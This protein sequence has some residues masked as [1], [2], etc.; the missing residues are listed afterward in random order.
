[1]PHTGKDRLLLDSLY[2]ISQ[3]AQTTE[4]PTEALQHILN[5][6]VTLLPGN[7]A[8]IELINPDSLQLEIEVSHGFPS[9]SADTRLPIGHGITGWVA[10]HG[11]PLIVSDVRKDSRY[12]CLNPDVRSEMAVPL[13]GDEGH[14][15]G[16]VNIDSVHPDA[17]DREDL[18]VLTLITMEAGR[19]INKIWHVQQLREKTIH[20]ETLLDV[21][22]S[23]VTK[24]DLDEIL[25]TITRQTLQLLKGRT[26]AIFF[27][28]AKHQTLTL[29]GFSGMQQPH[30]D[31]KSVSLQDSAIGTAIRWNKMIEVNDLRRTEE[32][33]F[34]RF[35]RQEGLVSLLSCPMS[36]E[37]E[38][39]GVLNLYTD[40]PHRFNNEEKRLMETL[41]SLGAAAVQNARLYDRIFQSEE[42]LRQNERLTTLGL[43]SAEIAHEIR[44]PLT[45]IRLLF[46]T[47]SLEFEADDPRHRDKQVIGEKLDQLEEIVSRVLQFGKARHDLKRHFNLNELI[48]D[49]LVLVRPKLRQCRVEV[50]FNANAAS[51]PLVDVSKGQLQQAIL[52][53]IINA[54]QAMPG[55][56]VIKI[57]SGLR[58]MNDQRC[59]YVRFADSGQGIPGAIRDQIFEFF[60]SG[61]HEGTGL[62]LAVVKRILKSHNGDVAV[63]DST[64][65]GTVM[66]FWLPAI[67]RR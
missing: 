33:H 41:A 35:I 17:F 50:E 62:G 63:I 7:S 30:A 61:R 10:L 53:I 37:N 3:L 66:E 9:K 18:K 34:I 19:V 26:C 14:V 46:E 67:D 22:R 54:T 8:A 55:G 36:F 57:E 6:M 52:N 11:E 20:Q 40:K 16:V 32:H 58:P 64:D 5:E 12:V 31:E 1:M 49:T 47:L 44:N 45:V 15:I 24:R 13:R 29:R 48:D 43:L 65:E 27:H 2:R 51:P 59:A 25:Q 28:D 38:V 60:L 4:N 56:G 23:M 21:A 39:I 42:S